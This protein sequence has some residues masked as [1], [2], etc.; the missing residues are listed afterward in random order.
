MEKNTPTETVEG[1][2]VI[3]TL[4]EREEPYTT[5]SE[6]KILGQLLLTNKHLADTGEC[7]VALDITLVAE[8]LFG[9]DPRVGN[10]GQEVIDIFNKHMEEVN[11]G[12]AKEQAARLMISYLNMV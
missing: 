1:Y 5:N 3:N 10:N 8:K 2:F 6:L 12:N 7:H 9:I 4:I 11:R